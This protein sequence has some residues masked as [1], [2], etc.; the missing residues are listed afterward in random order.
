MLW[1]VQ[2][3]LLTIILLFSEIIIKKWSLEEKQFKT[4]D[5]AAKIFRNVLNNAEI[6]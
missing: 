6:Q 2:D 5:S 3:L 1:R 4:G